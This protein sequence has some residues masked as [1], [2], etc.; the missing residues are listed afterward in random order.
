[1]ANVPSSK[2]ERVFSTCSIVLRDSLPDVDGAMLLSNCASGP[3]RSRRLRASCKCSTVGSDGALL[4]PGDLAKR[5][6]KQMN[7]SYAQLTED[8][9]VS[10]REQVRSYLPL[11]IE[12]FAA[13]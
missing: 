10:D 9:K 2:R 1:M 12:A 7:T 6:E 11:I 4:I 3:P 8:E 5:W 13:A